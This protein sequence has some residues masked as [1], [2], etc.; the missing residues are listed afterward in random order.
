MQH[1]QAYMM[2]NDKGFFIISKA[3]IQDHTGGQ[4]WLPCMGAAGM[5]LFVVI[6][7]FGVILAFCSPLGRKSNV[8]LL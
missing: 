6:T 4:H 7:C 5:Q 8:G 3:R 2:I 1:V